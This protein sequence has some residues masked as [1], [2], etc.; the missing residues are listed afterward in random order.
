M[1]QAEALEVVDCPLFGA[2]PTWHAMDDDRTFQEIAA[3]RG[4]PALVDERVVEMPAAPTVVVVGEL[5]TR[6]LR[7]VAS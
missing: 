7:V 4:H 5:D 1:T 2:V 3:T 6:P